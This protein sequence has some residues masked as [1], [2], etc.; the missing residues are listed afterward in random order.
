MVGGY[1]PYSD[2]NQ[3]IYNTVHNFRHGG[4]RGAVALAPL[5][6]MNPGTLRNKAH[7][8]VETHHLTVV[9]SIPVQIV[10]RDCSIHHA[11]SR[12]L[13]LVC[14]SL[15]KFE[16]T[17]DVDLVEAMAKW[18]ADVGETATAILECLQAQKVTRALLD[19]L[20]Q[21]IYDDAQR[22]L[23][24]WRRLNALVEGE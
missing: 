12:L 10:T 11:A 22:A 17:S 8:E 20:A 19:K 4:K 24:I 14:I 15:N 16:G 2:I 5:V 1:E 6:G 7:P 13:G 21:E 23:E 18:Q 3:A 9:E